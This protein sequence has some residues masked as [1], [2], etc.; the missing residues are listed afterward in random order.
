[1][2]LRLRIVVFGFVSCALSLAAVS[3]SKAPVT[4]K[5]TT[6]CSI[7]SNPKKYDNKIVKVSG[8]LVISPEYSILASDDCTMGVW[9]VLEEG[10][11][12]PGLIATVNPAKSA[13]ARDDSK[14]RIPVTLVR[15]SSF[16]E[17]KKL[18]ELSSK[19]ESCIEQL[20]QSG[21]IP[22][23]RTYRISATFTGRI[24][25]MRTKNAGGYGHM[26]LF[27]AQLVVQ[28]VE[29]IRAIY[30]DDSNGKEGKK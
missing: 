17:L 10:A 11:A 19:A 25:G 26:G 5:E 27:K 8:Y 16:A 9:F 23:C 7:V 3:G 6:V 24:D 12:Q 14:T 18:L 22:D 4:P 1:M 13:K 15:D 2:N 30:R 29:N 20:S 28:R 21:P